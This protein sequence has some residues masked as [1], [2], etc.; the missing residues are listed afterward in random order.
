[1]ARLVRRDTVLFGDQEAGQ[2]QSI[3]IFLQIERPCIET[4][5]FQISAGLSPTSHCMGTAFLRLNQAFPSPEG[6][7]TVTLPMDVEAKKSSESTMSLS[8]GI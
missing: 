4:D 5:H 6:A 2:R 8:Q 7:A 1:M 3:Y